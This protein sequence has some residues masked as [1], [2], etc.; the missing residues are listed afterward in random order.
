MVKSWVFCNLKCTFHPGRWVYL[1]D[2]IIQWN[3]KLLPAGPV[4]WLFFFPLSLLLVSRVANYKG[5]NMGMVLQTKQGTRGPSIWMRNKRMYGFQL[6]HQGQQKTLPTNPQTKSEST[7]NSSSCRV[8]CFDMD[9]L[10]WRT[11]PPS[12]PDCGHVIVDHWCLWMC[13]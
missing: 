5:T 9:D 2:I 4:H 6:H 13:W 3:F 10:A 11:S 7:F 8:K 12:S 1:N